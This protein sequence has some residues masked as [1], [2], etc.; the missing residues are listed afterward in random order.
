[1]RIAMAACDEGFAGMQ[2]QTVPG[3]TLCIESYI[4]EVGGPDG[5]KLEEQI[6]VTDAGGRRIVMHPL[7]GKLALKRLVRPVRNLPKLLK[8]LRNL[9]R[10]ANL[11]SRRAIRSRSGSKP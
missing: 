5:I 4:D 10:P 3:M 7:P 1:M 6:L 11:Y 8:S 2:T 9:S